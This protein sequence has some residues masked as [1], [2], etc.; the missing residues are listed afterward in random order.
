[1]TTPDEQL[2]AVVALCKQAGEAAMAHYVDPEQSEKADG[3]PLTAAD[4]AANQVLVAGLPAIDPAPILS[5]ESAHAPWSERQAWTRLW[6]VDPIDG[7]K[8][9][10][11]RNDQFTVNVALV[12]DGTPVLGVV[13]APALDVTY[14]ARVGQGAWV[15]REGGLTAIQ[16]AGEPQ[17]GLEV[18]GSRSHRSPELERFM[19]ALGPHRELTMGSSLKL[20]LVAEGRAHLYPRI[21]PTME[22]DTAAAHAVAAATGCRVT[23]LAGEPLRYNKPELLNPHFVVDGTDSAPWRRA[24]AE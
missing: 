5:E 21:G 17:D 16:R 15:E 11:K 13:H 24:I 2:L 6:L 1:M 19:Q 14:L 9:F 10:L 20:C 4:L 23:D 8:E 22:W 12:A 7:T 3:S 18:V